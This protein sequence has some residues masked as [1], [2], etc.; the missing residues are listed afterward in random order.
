MKDKPESVGEQ[1]YEHRRLSFVAD[2]LIRSPGDLEATPV[3]PIG[4]TQNAVLTPRMRPKQA[5]TRSILVP[6]AY[7]GGRGAGVQSGIQPD[8]VNVFNRQFGANSSFD[9]V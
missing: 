8:M 2:G 6:A 4:T 3:D 5:M 7:D 9:I 1:C